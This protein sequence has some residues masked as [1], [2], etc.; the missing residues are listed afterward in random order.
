MKPNGMWHT[1]WDDEGALREKW[2]KETDNLREIVLD[3]DLAEER[4]CSG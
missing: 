2:Q 4:R 1:R 3:C